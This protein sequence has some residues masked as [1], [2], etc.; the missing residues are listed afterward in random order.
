MSQSEIA[1]LNKRRMRV[2]CVI[3]CWAFALSPT[4][5]QS[6]VNLLEAGVTTSG[7]LGP[8]SPATTYAFDAAANSSATVTLENVSGGSLA[9][10][11]S[12]IN[13]NTLAQALDSAAS[14]A[15][16]A[17]DVLLTSGGRYHVFVYFSPGSGAP[18]T[19]FDIRLDLAAAGAADQPAPATTEAPQL[20]LL[21][22]GIEAR[23]SWIGAA[24]LNL[25]V[26]DPAGEALHWNSR[27]TNTGGVFGFDANGLCEVLGASPEESAIWQPGFLSSGSYE[28]IIYYEQACDT[29]TGTVPFELAVT[30]DGVSA[31]RLQATLAPSGASGKN[32]YVTRFEVAAD[33]S[34]QLSEGGVYP[35]TSLT[36]LPSGFDQSA[37]GATAILR[38]TPVRGYISNAAP[39]VTYS[40][41]GAADELVTLN[42]NA[43][44]P[45]LDTLLQIVDP[46]GKVV[47]VNDDAVFGS[48]DSA[49][50]NAR[51]LSS[52]AYT[53]IAT[54]YAKEIGGTEGQFEIALSG[55]TSD[56]AGQAT[57]LNLPP[58]DIAVSLYWSTTADLQ[59]LVRD[60]AGASVFDDSPLVA[61]GGILQEAGN[62][63][64]VP[65]ESGAPV[66][67]IYW[68][69]GTMRPG[70]YEVEVWYQ[71]TCSELPPPVDFTLLIEVNGTVV[72]DAREFPQ[73]GQRYVTNFTVTPAGTAIVGEAGFIDA[74]SATLAYQEAAFDAPLMQYGEQVTGVISADNAFDVYRFDGAAGDSVTISMAA[75][76]QT[77]DTNLYLISPGDREIAAN[78]DA[79]PVLLG[80]ASRTTDSLIS[81]FVL[82]EN[83]PHTIIATRYANQYGGTLGVYTL[84]LQRN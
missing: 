73:P 74:G 43:I 9:L 59:L 45:S 34:A 30:V 50:V 37:A 42:M 17:G 24:D 28:V 39:F 19:S 4:L 8:A 14:G 64:C 79:D 53:I 77:L 84:T 69:P 46:A 25:E 55:P 56:L 70:P 22:A 58:G 18:D 78:D 35:D 76:T 71:N 5:A 65:A 66:S 23:L 72:A 6:A 20:I 48:T 33:G 54:R 68:P 52:G 3:L 21:G 15:V 57:S 38:G 83:G 49:I 36:A 2:V 31:G 13:G 61:S 7:I 40:F 60:P 47:H 1:G 26:R 27:T 29:L 82:A 12:D 51:L 75:A 32:V 63:N 44:G 80:T 11:I 10:L 62:V 16:A 41:I 67:Y 81:G